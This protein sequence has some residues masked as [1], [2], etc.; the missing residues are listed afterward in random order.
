MLDRIVNVTIRLFAQQFPN[1]VARIESIGTE[2][3]RAVEEERDNC[4]LG[5]V[6]C[7]V[8]FGIVRPQL[9]LVDVL[10]KNISKYIRV[11]LAL[12]TQR[13]IIQP[14]IPRIEEG[15]HALKG[16]VGNL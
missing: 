4:V 2:F 12:I 9:F 5:N 1:T 8:L 13:T 6:L 15:K 14:P 10:F 16:S 7:Y 11:N 3:L